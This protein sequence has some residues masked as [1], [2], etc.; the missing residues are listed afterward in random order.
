[1]PRPT[2][3]LAGADVPVLSGRWREIYPILAPVTRPFRGV[4]RL[5][6]SLVPTGK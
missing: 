4:R 1:M 2:P 3:A 5:Q 6:L